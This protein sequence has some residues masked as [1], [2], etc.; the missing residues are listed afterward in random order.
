MASLAGE[1]T[2][3]HG[4]CLPAVVDPAGAPTFA[5]SVDDAAGGALGWKE[6]GEDEEGGDYAGI[7]YRLSGKPVGS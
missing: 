2:G 6:Q 5:R 4:G 3:Q 1:L 7:V